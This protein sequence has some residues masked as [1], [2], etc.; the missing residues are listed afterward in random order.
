MMSPGHKQLTQAQ[1][2]VDIIVN[3]VFLKE[4]ICILI[5]IALKFVLKDLIVNKSALVQIMMRHL[6]SDKPLSELI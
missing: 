3:Y 1:N 6:A 5:K 4:N 2:F